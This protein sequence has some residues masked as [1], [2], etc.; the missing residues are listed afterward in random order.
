MACGDHLTIYRATN[1]SLV[2]HIREQNELLVDKVGVR[3]VVHS[4]SIEQG[5]I[6]AQVPS[7]SALLQPMSQP[8]LTTLNTLLAKCLQKGVSIVVQF[9]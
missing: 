1:G 2:I 8:L 6:V 7:L 3:D 4:L 5:L 9:V